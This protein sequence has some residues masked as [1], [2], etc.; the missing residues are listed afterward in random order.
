MVMT[1][2][3]VAFFDALAPGHG[4]TASS[5]KNDGLC[6][7]NAR[8]PQRRGVSSGRYKPTALTMT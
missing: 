3:D 1:S 5:V 4:F 2:P 8:Y 7:T 6:G